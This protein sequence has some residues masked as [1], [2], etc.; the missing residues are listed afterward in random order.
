[1]GCCLRLD[2][3]QTNAPW[4]TLCGRIKLSTTVFNAKELRVK[5][6]RSYSVRSSLS[7]NL[8]KTRFELSLGK[9]PSPESDTVGLFSKCFYSFIQCFGRSAN[10]DDR[11]SG[12][13]ISTEFDC[14][15]SVLKRT[16][17][18]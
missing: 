18:R 7:V 10:R 14:A 15:H 13:T 5:K 3:M 11:A 6:E 12:P 8:G 4:E 17:A 1:M 2:Q 16:C 9:S